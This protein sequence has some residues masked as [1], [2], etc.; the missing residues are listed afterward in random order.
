MRFITGLFTYTFTLTHRILR[1]LESVKYFDKTEKGEIAAL[2]GLN[3]LL[4]E[5]RAIARLFL[6][7]HPPLVF[8]I[9][10]LSGT[11]RAIG[12]IKRDIGQNKR[13]IGTTERAIGFTK[14][15]IIFISALRLAKKIAKKTSP[16]GF[17]SRLNAGIE[18]PKDSR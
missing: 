13:D 6:L 10:L 17:F 3:R 18:R 14:G 15:A 8:P 9:A 1:K 16:D 11:E 5:K 4:G 7:R 12:K 2:R